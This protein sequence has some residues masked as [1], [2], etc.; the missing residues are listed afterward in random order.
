MGPDYPGTGH[1]TVTCTAA[2]SGG[3]TGWTIV[4][5]VNGTNGTLANLY[6]FS[7]TG[8]LVFDAVYRNSFDVDLAQ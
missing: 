2:S 1:A 6:H 8:S 4:S 5:N 7:N 3:C